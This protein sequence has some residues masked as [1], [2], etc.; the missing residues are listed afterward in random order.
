[1]KKLLI[2]AG[3]ADS[4]VK[5]QQSLVQLRL[6]SDTTWRPTRNNLPELR[7]ILFGFEAQ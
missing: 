5:C 3:W 4:E 2:S 1:M 6:N 7:S